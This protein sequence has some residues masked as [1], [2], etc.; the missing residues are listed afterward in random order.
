M[1]EVSATAWAEALPVRL[2]PSSKT[3]RKLTAKGFVAGR[4]RTIDRQVKNN[5]SCV[6][7]HHRSRR[8]ALRTPL[9]NKT[10]QTTHKLDEKSHNRG[11]AYTPKGGGRIVVH[12]RS[13]FAGEKP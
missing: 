6:S 3:L 2:P 5:G 9:R 12:H 11:V 1:T 7:L 8:A 13:E 10:I 4:G